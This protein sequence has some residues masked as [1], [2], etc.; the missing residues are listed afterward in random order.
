MVL[1]MTLRTARPTLMLM[2]ALCLLLAVPA[3]AHDPSIEDADWGE[4][5]EPVQTADATISYAL[6]GYLDSDDLDVFALDFPEAGMLLRAEV[7][8][9]VCGAHYADFYPQMVILAP[10]TEG[11][12]ALELT[13]PFEIPA[14]LIPISTAEPEITAEATSEPDAERATFVEPFGGTAFYEAPRIDLEVPAPG[15]YYVAVYSP[16]GQ[17]GDYTLATGYRE[18]FNSPRQQMLN[19]VMAI[20]SGNWLHRRCDLPPDDPEAI[21]EPEHHDD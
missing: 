18:E 12:A 3:A 20:R 9:P 17:T 19:A 21:I 1:D 14:D 10:A 4:F 6:Y 2:L 13:L 8:V 11:V 15:R 7:L 5:E 16:D